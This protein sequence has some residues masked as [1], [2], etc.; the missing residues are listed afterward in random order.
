MCNVWQHSACHDIS[1]ASAEKE[2]FHF[3]CRDCER[4]KE[5]AKKPK[6]PS[7]KF[8]LGASSSPPSEQRLKSDGQDT[9]L[10]KRTIDDYREESPSPKR[11]KHVEIKATASTPYSNPRPSGDEHIRHLGSLLSGPTLSPDGQSPMPSLGKNG[12]VSHPTHP[13]PGLASPTESR[14]TSNGYLRNPLDAPPTYQQPLSSHSLARKQNEVTHENGAYLGPPSLAGS[15][16]PTQNRLT[17]IAHTPPPA[18]ACPP[19]N[20]F[21]NSFDRQR[22]L[23]SHSNHSNVS[24]PSP[25]KNRPSMSPKASPAVGPLAFLQSGSPNGVFAPPHNGKAVY[26]PQKHSSPPAGL[27]LPS[28]PAPNPPLPAAASGI[29]PTKHSPPRPSSNHS[30]AGTPVVPPVTSLSPSPMQQ[31]F[32]PPHKALPFEQPRANGHIIT[33]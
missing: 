29:S 19:Q 28:T 8:R 4:R 30:V 23:S 5:D 16:T 10:K 20:P 17:S 3:I 27:S 26:S 31:D 14:L 7:L 24:V 21:L 25:L 18:F 32:S 2:D 9:V 11:L 13:P 12:V 1:Q 22:P 6:I 15:T 33:Q